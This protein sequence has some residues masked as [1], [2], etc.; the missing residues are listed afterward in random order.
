[1]GRNERKPYCIENMVQGYEMSVITLW[2][3]PRE[4][5]FPS[6]AEYL[7][8]N[9]EE[10]EKLA[11]V[12][13]DYHKKMG[14]PYY[15]TDIF[16]R[17]NKYQQLQRTDYIGL[18]EEDNSIRQ[19]MVGSSL[20]FSYMPHAYSVQCNKERTPVMSF[21]NDEIFMK[22]I[23]K[24]M[25]LK[26]SLTR[27]G[28]LKTL[29]I[30]SAQSVSNFRPS[31]AACL[32]HHLDCKGK[33]VW[34]M[35]C[36]YGGRLLGANTV[37]VGKYIGTEPCDLTYNGLQEI[38]RDWITIPTEIHKC[39]SEDYCPQSESIDICLT[40]PPYFDTEK[41]SNEENQSW[42]KYPTKEEW[43][44]GFLKKTFENCFFGL[45]PNGKM[46]INIA[47][48]K[49]YTN[50]EEDTV[51]IAEE[52]GFKLIDTWKLS[53]SSIP[54]ANKDNRGNKYEPIFIFQKV[55]DMK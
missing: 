32:Y 7:E 41:Y 48:V 2:E 1:L 53:L 29:R 21:E 44:N 11:K 35:S 18:L 47:N 26:H 24:T 33:V 9:E 3:K 20:C 15:P 52:C 30:Y 49:T 5:R 55:M 14:F 12:L 13:F 8:Y 10:L 27:S 31:A 34:D 36:G 54:G 23:R 38:I 16:W 39:G 6:C 25:R 4:K 45:K 50:L 37:G 22:V 42:I 28:V 19:S 43:L 51:R 17:Y 46:V 40:S